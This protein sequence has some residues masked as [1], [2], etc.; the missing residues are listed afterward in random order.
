MFKVLKTFFFFFKVCATI[1]VTPYNK[2]HPTHFSRSFTAGGRIW[3]FLTE[4]QFVFRAHLCNTVA[5]D[6]FSWVRCKQQES[7]PK[8]ERNR[9]KWTQTAW[10]SGI[11]AKSKWR[12]IN[13]LVP[14]PQGPL[15]TRA[16]T[17]THAKACVHACTHTDVFH[18]IGL[19]GS[20]S[21][22]WVSVCAHY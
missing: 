10:E 18:L 21:K 17:N 12:E 1:N 7:G 13:P 3:S 6:V 22:L 8:R 20:C 2:L 16:H 9:V 19:V 4:W 11:W 15:S 14:T 5:P